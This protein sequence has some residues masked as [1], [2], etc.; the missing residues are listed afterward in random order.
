[1]SLVQLNHASAAEAMT[2]FMRCC[3]STRWARALVGAR[4][5]ADAAALF[6]VA[7][8]AWAATG[9]EDWREAISHH[10]RI[11]DL[12]STNGA[13]SSQEQQG[14]SGAAEDVLQA[15]A[16]ENSAYEARFGFT[17]LVCATGRSAAQMLAL[18]QARMP[19]APAEELR[20]AAGE[21]AKITRIRLEKLLTP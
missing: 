11:G 10:P 3:G 21:Q 17:F 19:N 1:M 7:E 8:D 6:S 14:V 5:F 9:P 2:E 12:A 20:V 18:L 16:A 4:P 15:L 13:W